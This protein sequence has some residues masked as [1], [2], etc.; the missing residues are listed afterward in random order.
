[1]TPTGAL[2]LGAF[3]ASLVWLWGWHIGSG[4]W[5]D[6]TAWWSERDGR[7]GGHSPR[8]SR[9]GFRGKSREGAQRVPPTRAAAW[10]RT[11]RRASSL[12]FRKVAPPLVSHYGKRRLP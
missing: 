9:S 2:I 4:L 3:L 10:P 5:A 12:G 7:R 1:M 6:L 11:V 8:P